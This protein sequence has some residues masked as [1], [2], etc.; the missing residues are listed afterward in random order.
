M[1]RSWITPRF[2][3]LCWE[4]GKKCRDFMNCANIHGIN[5]YMGNRACFKKRFYVCWLPFVLIF[6]T[7]QSIASPWLIVSTTCLN[8]LSISHLWLLNNQPSTGTISEGTLTKG[9]FAVFPPVSWEHD[10][11]ILSVHCRLLLCLP[12]IIFF[13]ACPVS[14][15]FFR[16][17]CKWF[18]DMPSF[19]L[20][21]LWEWQ[22]L[23]YVVRLCYSWQ[24]SQIQL[25]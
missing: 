20:T 1:Q 24:F 5:V 13:S 6:D 16:T 18:W 7:A 8:F 15:T 19:W 4:N 2:F 3:V 25:N 22:N 9:D 10:F 21:A 23:F 11:Q 17:H 14:S 12:L